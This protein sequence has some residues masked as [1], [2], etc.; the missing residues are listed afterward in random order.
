M[1]NSIAS[2]GISSFGSLIVKSF[3]YSSFETLLFNIPFGVIQI[4]AI[5]GSAWLATRFQRKGLVIAAFSVLPC[6]GTIL[7]LAVPREQKGVLLFGYY[8]V[9]PPIHSPLAENYLL[10]DNLC[11]C[12]VWRPLRLSC[13]H[14]KRRIRAAT[15]RRNVLRP[16]SSLGCAQETSSVR[17]FSLQTM[18]RCTGLD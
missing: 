17:F 8:L 10:V 6:I 4:L 2:G 14:G 15:P 16:W 1:I 12:L 7:M 9:C 3:G 13:T 18:P 11:R 5:I